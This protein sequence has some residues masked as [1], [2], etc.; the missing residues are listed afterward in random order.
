[1]SSRPTAQVQMK[2]HAYNRADLMRS[3][4]HSGT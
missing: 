4:D 2:L 1:M 3:E